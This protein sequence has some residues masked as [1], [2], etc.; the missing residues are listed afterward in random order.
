MLFSDE[1][2]APPTTPAPDGGAPQPQPPAL[3]P[4]GGDKPRPKLTVI[5]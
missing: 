2:A 1:D 3:A 5:K 4:S